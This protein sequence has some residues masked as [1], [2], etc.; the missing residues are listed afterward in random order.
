MITPDETVAANVRSNPSQAALRGGPFVVVVGATLA[1]L[2]FAVSTRDEELLGAGACIWL[3]LVALALRAARGPL[4]RTDPFVWVNVGMVVMFGLHPIAMVLFGV[5]DEPFRLHYD[6]RPTYGEAVW[7][8]FLS[9][10]SFNLAVGVTPAL[11]RL[12]RLQKP[13]P[14]CPSDV[15]LRRAV[16]LARPFAFV[17]LILAAVGYGLFV[18]TSGTPIADA[19]SSGF[20]RGDA[21][22]TT[23]YFYFAPALVGPAAV[24][25]GYRALVL[26]RVPLG[27]AVLTLAQMV[28]LFGS[29]QRQVLLLSVVPAVMLYFVLTR[30]RLGAFALCLIVV[31]VL[32]ALVSARDLGSVSGPTPARSLSETLD[33]PAER[34]QQ[35]LTGAD[36][37]MVDALAL[38]LQFVPSQLAHSP[39]LTALSVAAAPVPSAL[40]TS[41]PAP[42]DVHLN[43]YLLRVQRNNASIAYS[44]TGEL[45]FDSGWLGVILGFVLLGAAAVGVYRMKEHGSSTSTRI[46]AYVSLVPLFVAVLRGGLA[47]TV[48]RSLFSVVPVV[49]FSIVVCWRSSDRDGRAPRSRL[50]AMPTSERLM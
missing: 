41:K 31:L 50:G 6:L 33:S 1:Y 39:G 30:R 47:Y 2:A 34:A 49:I 24:L 9:V 35:L 25:L 14:G 12:A 16:H 8:G 42:A 19:L 37:E 15:E 4:D 29:G 46:L 44:F 45:Y 13:R 43:S 36:T 10:L 11:L 48:G 40:W 26:R 22:D 3:C 27:A 23:A 7:L 28:V 32:V 21:T 17:L 20:R 18:V 5:I 38:E